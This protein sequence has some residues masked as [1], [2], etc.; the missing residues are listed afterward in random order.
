MPETAL[1][2]HQQASFT[3]THDPQIGPNS[4]WHTHPTAVRVLLDGADIES[5][6]A[7]PS[8]TQERVAGV[9]D[10]FFSDE[11]DFSKTTLE[12]AG[13]ALFEQLVAQVPELSQKQTAY[14]LKDVR[15]TIEY[16]GSL[17]HPSQTIEFSRSVKE[18][19]EPSL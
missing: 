4:E 12:D 6:E 18:P 15:F 16:D 17:D 8:H 10:R 5:I 1:D 3:H 2:F 14:I 9:I 11:N 7:L 13:A 19:A